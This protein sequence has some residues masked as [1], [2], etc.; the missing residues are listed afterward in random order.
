MS[1]HSSLSSQ[2]PNT[3]TLSEI[4][5]LLNLSSRDDQDVLSEAIDVYFTYPN[6][7]PLLEDSDNRKDTSSSSLS[8]V[9][10]TCKMFK[11]LHH[12]TRLNHRVL[13]NI[14]L[15]CK[16]GIIRLNFD[17]LEC[18]E[19]PFI[20]ALLSPTAENASDDEVS[21][22]VERNERTE[23][24]VSNTIE[25]SRIRRI[26]CLKCGELTDFLSPTGVCDSPHCNL[27]DY[28]KRKHVRFNIK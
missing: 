21:D 12:V 9:K 28:A 3:R 1:I 23:N 8:H 6:I 24:T 14:P 20:R 17:T 15:P 11:N 18:N 26:R 10:K 4:F 7:P 16:S 22:T 2:N 5:Q 25:S 13:K 27:N 19:P